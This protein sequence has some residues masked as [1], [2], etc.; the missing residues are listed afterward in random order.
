[1]KKPI[2]R[3]IIVGGGS[4]GWMTAAILCKRFPEKEIALIESPDVPTV[5]VGESTLGSINAFLHMLDLKDS[6]WMEYCNATYKL[7]IKFRDF[8]KKGETFHYPFGQKDVKNTQRGVDDWYFKKTT[9][10][11]TP[12]GDFV[13]SFYPQMPLIHQNKIFDNLNNEI[14]L[15][16]FQNDAAYHMDASLF[17]KYLREEYCTP[18]GVVFI[19]EHVDQYVVGQDG[20]LSHL[21]LRNGDELEADLFIDCTG[22]RSQILE[23][24]MGV[25]FQSF[26]PWLPNNR[27]WTVHVPYTD[28]EQEI[29]NVTC[30]TAINNGWVWNIPLFNRIGSGYVFCSKFISE[31]DALD[32]YKRYL[33]SEMMT[34]YNPNR[35][36]D[37]EFR[38]VKIKNGVHDVAWKNNVVAVGLSYGFIEPLEST[39]LLSVQEI[40][41]LLCE[42]LENHQVNKI[43]V[44][45]FNY[46]LNT[47]M[48]GFKLFVAYHYTFSSRRDTP[49]WKYVTEQI[50]MDARMQDDYLR[51]LQT[52]A[53]DYG[54]RLLRSHT[55]RED[56]GG[57]VDVLVGM[58]QKP[59]NRFAYDWHLYG[60]KVKGVKDVKMFLESTQQYWNTRNAHVT[61]VANNAPSHYQYLKNRIYKN[62]KEG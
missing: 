47:M 22:F 38:L 18:R 55:F 10:P 33:D 58:N 23:E 4:A 13:D 31:P 30:C 34:V 5:G 44:D 49:Y 62:K 20:D 45:N 60:M 52:V 12:I 39:G 42:T 29:E 17:G 46:V 24:A 6:D 43:H 9:Q 35:S 59:M 48:H 8:Y 14:P 50:T 26:E 7:S 3:I 53:I 27:A 54:V 51:G 57:M 56:M 28:K 36:K 61:R 37:L 15:F 2:N 11:E 32:E 19:Q 21:V 41:I 25:P 40:L 16:N 1:M